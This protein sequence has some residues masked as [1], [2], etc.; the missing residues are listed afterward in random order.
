[1][2]E[3]PTRSLTEIQDLTQQYASFSQS[4]NGLGNV[5]GGIA[6]L[7]ISGAILLLG[8]GLPI[9]VLTVG[10]TIA[11]LVG[12]EALRRRLYRA[13][14]EASETWPNDRRR[15][16]NICIAVLGAICAAFFVVV[17]V[18]VATAA[19]PWSI[20]VPYMV[21]CAITPWIAWRYLRTVNEFMVGFYLLF[22]SAVAC[23]GFVPDRFV[24]LAILPVYSLVMIAA[25]WQ[26]HRQF[27]A[28]ASRLRGTEQ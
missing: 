21:F 8:R 13:F 19:S 14:G 16:F 26:E 5:A 2:M 7:I 6:G 10:L 25:G 22:A 9:A 4:R 3:A 27:Q 1:M 12:K 23:A 15:I 17:A 20:G 18:R 11:W 28:L 24:T